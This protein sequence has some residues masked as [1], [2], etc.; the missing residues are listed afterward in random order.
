[1]CRQLLDLLCFF[2][3]GAYA[4]TT[5]L[6]LAFSTIWETSRFENMTF[7]A[8]SALPKSTPLISK[9]GASQALSP[10]CW[11]C[12]EL[13]DESTGFVLLISLVI[14]VLG[15]IQHHL[16]QVWLEKGRWELPLGYTSWDLQ[17]VITWQESNR[18]VR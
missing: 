7:L 5:K 15:F 10:A 14:F 17:G 16:R 9:A 3:C 18:V 1:M 11:P 4:S 2:L 6:V 13:V 12:P 8:L